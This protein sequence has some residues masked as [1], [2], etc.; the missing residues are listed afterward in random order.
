MKRLFLTIIL[1]KKYEK[2]AYMTS[3]CNHLLLIVRK[4]TLR[5]LR[6]KLFQT[7]KK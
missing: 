3:S 6:F 5:T 4:T 2:L 7:L 1:L